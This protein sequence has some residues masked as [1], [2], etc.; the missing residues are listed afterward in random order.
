MTEW[1]WKFRDD[2]EDAAD[3]LAPILREWDYLE[4]RPGAK[5]LKSNLLRKVISIPASDELPALIVKRYHVRSWRERL[6]YFLT[7]SRAQREWEALGTFECCGVTGPRRLA[8]GEVRRGGALTRAGLIMETVEHAVPLPTALRGARPCD[9]EALFRH[10]GTEIARMHAAGVDHTDLHAGNIL[11]STR[12]HTVYLLDLH[13]T[14]LGAALPVAR[15]TNN[16]A[17]LFHS[18]SDYLD[19]PRARALLDAYRQLDP[20]V[21]LPPTSRW[22][23]RLEAQARAL[24]NVRLRSRSKRCWRNSSEFV[25]EARGLWRIHRRRDLDPELLDPYLLGKIDLDVIYKD[26]KDQ[27]VGSTTLMTPSGLR[28]IVVKTRRYSS[29]FKRLSYACIRGPLERAWGA[30]RALD[31]REIP[32]PRA[33]ALMTERRFGLPFQSVLL[34]EHAGTAEPLHSD[35]FERFL[36]PGGDRRALHAETAELARLVRRLHD[37]GIYH[38]DLNPMNFLI[39]RDEGD[40]PRLL[41][42]DLDSIHLG[43]RLNDRRRHKNLVQ[44]GLLPEGHITTRDRLRFLRDYDRGDGRYFTEAWIRSLSESIADATV[45]IIARMSKQEA[46][47]VENVGHQAFCREE[48]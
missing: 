3:R 38:R 14:Y 29:L 7:A 23:D 18:L 40:G 31:V 46:A 22:V 2:S 17:R 15:R 25:K 44:L 24:E 13:A 8:M 30:A 41:L 6:K 11:V 42:V 12:G 5:V 21:E 1:T 10:V 35:L 37:T 36:S 45:K 43:R 20:A 27:T 26:R 32:N 47:G 48:Q 4:E 19:Y 34:T 16:L 9:S 39:G 28:K 33:L